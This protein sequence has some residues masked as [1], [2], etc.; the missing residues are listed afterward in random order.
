MGRV[1]NDIRTQLRTRN[2]H[3]QR[4][5]SIPYR[6]AYAAMRD[7]KSGD[8]WVHH[9]YAGTNGTL[10]GVGFSR[11]GT[12][13][14][15]DPSRGHRHQ[16]RPTRMGPPAFSVPRD[17]HSMAL[18]GVRRCRRFDH[19]SLHSRPRHA[20]VGRTH[21]PGRDMHEHAAPASLVVVT[22]PAA[23]VVV[24]TPVR[25]MAEH[26]DVVGQ[27]PASPLTSRSTNRV[28]APPPARAP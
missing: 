20:A 27:F 11:R 6:R 16:R 1:V 18:G 23:G 22:V 5:E 24:R 26:P 15:A 10:S 21:V 12:A 17:G 7:L 3:D 13:H 8:L 4:R 9:D 19:G 28:I 25:A 14:V 2:S